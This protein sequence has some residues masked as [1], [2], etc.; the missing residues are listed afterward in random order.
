ME[1]AFEHLALGKLE[2]E[3]AWVSW[4]TVYQIVQVARWGD[5]FTIAGPI[6]ALGLH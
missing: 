4:M 5:T 6:E 3:N 2:L 1:I